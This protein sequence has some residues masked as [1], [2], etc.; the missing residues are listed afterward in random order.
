MPQAE[1]SDS[2]ALC[3]V[4]VSVNKTDWS[5][6]ERQITPGA[7]GVHSEKPAVFVRESWNA[8]DKWPSV[9]VVR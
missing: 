1:M 6:S 9:L 5:R 7:A 8:K 4:S 3:H 2:P